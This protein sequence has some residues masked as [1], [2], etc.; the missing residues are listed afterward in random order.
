M[1]K[2]SKRLDELPAWKQDGVLH[3][4]VECTRGS[5]MKL[6]YE[7]ELDAITLSR[8]LPLGVTFPFEFGFVPSTHAEDG[9][10]LDAAVLLD[11]AT[12]PGIVLRVRPIGV[13]RASQKGDAGRVRN[14]RLI[15]VAEA[16][17]RRAHV[18]DVD[19]LPARE[20]NEIERFFVAAVALEG[21]ELEIL[22]WGDAR[23]ARDAVAKATKPAK[24][25]R[26]SRSG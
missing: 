21:K 23:A 16:D 14:D 26:A 9:D 18:K 4:V 5:A 19:D 10:P 1:A 24:K 8:P 15:T 20:R 13:V 11:T 3:V 17:R 12:A 22:G 2:R 7:P 6:K 25:K